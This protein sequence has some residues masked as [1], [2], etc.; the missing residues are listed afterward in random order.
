MRN[1]T[2]SLAIVSVLFISSSAFAQRTPTK[3]M[4]AVAAEFG[5]S[6]P[7]DDSLQNGFDLA[8]ALDGYLSPRVSVR[9]QLG[10]S[11][12]DVQH[13]GFSGTVKPVRFDANLVYNWEGGAWHPFVTAGPGVYHFKATT[14]GV[15]GGETKLGANLGGGLEY[16]VNRRTTITGE[17]LY[18]AVPSFD[19]PFATFDGSYWTIDFGVK[20]YFGR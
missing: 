7:A 13:R 18:H 8:L 17:A 4:A 16:F 9:A 10:A 19:A 3:G 12:W 14:G 2:I 15:D 5:A 20:R 6:K 11:W 1:T